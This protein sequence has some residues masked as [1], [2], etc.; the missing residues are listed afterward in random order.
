MAVQAA[1]VVVVLGVVHYYSVMATLIILCLTVAPVILNSY[2]GWDSDVRASLAFSNHFQSVNILVTFL[3]STSSNVSVLMSLQYAAFDDG[4]KLPP[5]PPA[6]HPPANLPDGS[7][8]HNYK[9]TMSPGV[10]FDH[11]VIAITCNTTFQWM[12]I[13]RIILCPVTTE[14]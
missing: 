8:R 4:Q 7:Y 11:L 14:G 9:L 3:I 6:I 10:M 5:D 1:F 2:Y 13:N 12:A